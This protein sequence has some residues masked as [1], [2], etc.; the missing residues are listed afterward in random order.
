MPRRNA[1]FLCK[2]RCW[3]LFVVDFRRWATRYNRG[4]D[5]GITAVVISDRSCRTPGRPGA[6][7]LVR[8]FCIDLTRQAIYHPMVEIRAARFCSLL[9]LDEIRILMFR[10]L[11]LYVDIIM[12][13][14]YPTLCFCHI[15]FW[16]RKWTYIATHLVVVV[17]VVVLL[18]LVVVGRPSSSQKAQGSVVSNQ[19]GMKFGTI[20]LQ[21]NAYRLTESDVWDDVILSRWRPL[22]P[23]AVRCS[24]VWRLSTSP[25]SACD[26]IYISRFS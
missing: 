26:V 8:P 7:R 9:V 19:I 10:L 13:I 21:V 5:F 24:S 23:P 12:Q 17:V 18:L 16:T 15:Y 3:F 4:V 20:V 11:L 1:R 22:R 6:A 2:S 14:K 25:P